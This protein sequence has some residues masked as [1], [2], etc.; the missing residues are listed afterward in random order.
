VK[1]I[2][3]MVIDDESFNVQAFERSIAQITQYQIE[4]VGTCSGEEAV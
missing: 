2:K 3:I 4:F 1:K